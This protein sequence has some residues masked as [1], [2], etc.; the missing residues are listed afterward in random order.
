MLDLSEITARLTAQAPSLAQVLIP[1][2]QET[3]GVDSAAVLLSI[4]EPTI[5]SRI[6]PSVF[7]IEPTYPAAVYEQSNSERV[8]YDG[9]PIIR[10]DEYLV[11]V[12]ADTH[13]AVSTSAEAMRAALLAY[14][15]S[16]AAGS[17][18]IFGKADDFYP[19]LKLYEVSQVVQLTHLARASQSLPAVFVYA[20]D[21]DWEDED[22]ITC[23]TGQAVSRFVVLLVA[24]VPAGGVSA[25]GSIRDEILNALVAYKPTGW[26]QIEPE[27]GG[28]IEL[29]SAH[30]VWREAFVARQA[31]TY[32]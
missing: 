25:L 10:S 17:A 24:K 18:A 21:E 19:A 1:E 15:P 20:L 13:S 7:P 9:Y 26:G 8:D 11:A 2:A 5:S 3:Y 28:K 4:L 29:H 12:A 31:R 32:T 14:D 16:N 30:V 22:S 23:V 27:G 6:Y